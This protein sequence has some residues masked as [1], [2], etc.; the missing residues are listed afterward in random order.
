[1]I[2]NYIC[3][4]SRKRLCLVFNIFNLSLNILQVMKK[5]LFITLAM[6]AALCGSA[7]H[8][9]HRQG[10]QRYRSAGNYRSLDARGFSLMP[11]L[12]V[13]GSTFWG[14][15]AGGCDMRASLTAGLDVNYRLNRLISF[16][17]GV[18]FAMRGADIDDRAG[19]YLRINHIDIPMLINFHVGRGWSFYTGV[20]PSFKVWSKYRA[21]GV[22][23]DGDDLSSYDVSIP[24][25]VNYTLPSG[26]NFGVRATLGGVSIVDDDDVIYDYAPARGAAPRKDRYYYGGYYD[27][28]DCEIYNFDISFSIGYKFHL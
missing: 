6:L 8:Y 21:G 15:D 10:V 12:G 2:F 27:Y 22:E 26:I 18:G 11:R 23:Y 20:Q 19:G 17:S 4:L 25:G 5:Y 1:M 7:Q 24:I 9:G 13:G 14:D 16:T 28:D 3:S